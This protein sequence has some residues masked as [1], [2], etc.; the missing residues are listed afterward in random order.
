MRA[1]LKPRIS[2]IPAELW[3][4]HSNA[5]SHMG[6]ELTFCSPGSVSHELYTTVYGDGVVFQVYQARW[7][8]SGD[9]GI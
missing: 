8:F 9:R 5:M 7:Q 1:Q 4:L 6:K 3:N 2:Q